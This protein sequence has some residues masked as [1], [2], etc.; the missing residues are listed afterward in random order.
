MSR[1]TSRY[2]NVLLEAEVAPSQRTKFQEEYKQR[3]GQA[4]RLGKYYQLQRNKFGAELRVY[5]DASE[6]T[7]TRLKTKF[8]VERRAGG[9]HGDREF[10]INTQ[11][12][13]WHMVKR[14][15]RLGEN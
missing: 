10:R 11:N 12:F 9:Y 1:K 14:G 3:T 5:F 7:V 13:F 4:P 6:K 8:T 15:Y 2:K